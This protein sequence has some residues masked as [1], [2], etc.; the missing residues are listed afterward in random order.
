M[1]TQLSFLL[2]G[3]AIILKGPYL[4]THPDTVL[5][6]KYNTVYIRIHIKDSEIFSTE[7]KLKIPA[8]Y[9][10]EESQLVCTRESEHLES[11]TSYE[12][13]DLI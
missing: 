13:T 12:I 2:D 7:V 1:N 8:G 4:I 9:K 5:Y 3:Y 6:V 10:R 11:Y